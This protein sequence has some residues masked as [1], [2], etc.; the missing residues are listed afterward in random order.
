MQ[1]EFEFTLPRGY[2]DEDGTVHRQGRMRLA[3]MRDEAEATAHPQVQAYESYLPIIL[4][5]R[6]IVQLGSLT[7]VSPAMIDEQITLWQAMIHVLGTGEHCPHH[8]RGQKPQ[9]S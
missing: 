9:E 6:V 1:T 7:A 4:L 2:L 8:F 5:S 3:N